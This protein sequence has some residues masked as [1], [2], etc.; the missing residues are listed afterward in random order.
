[1]AT[2]VLPARLT[3]SEG[4]ATLERLLPLLQS[5][6]VVEL[7]AS[8]LRELDSAAVALLLAC[9]RQARSQGRDLRVIGMPPKLRQLVQLYG[10]DGLLMA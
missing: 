10:V 1:M 2:M 7:D 6:D 8:P 9:Q 3:M 4:R 5:A